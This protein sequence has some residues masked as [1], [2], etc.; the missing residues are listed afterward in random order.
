MMASTSRKR[1]AD[2]PTSTIHGNKI[3]CGSLEPCVEYTK[4]F[5]FP[6]GLQYKVKS[7][8][9]VLSFEYDKYEDGVFVSLFFDQELIIQKEISEKMKRKADHLLTFT[10]QIVKNSPNFNFVEKISPGGVFGDSDDDVEVPP[11]SITNPYAPEEMF[12]KNLQLRMLC[13]AYE[14]AKAVNFHNYQ[15]KHFLSLLINFLS[16]H[17]EK[18]FQLT[19]S[20]STSSSGPF[21]PGNYEVTWRTLKKKLKDRDQEYV[22]STACQQSCRCSSAGFNIKN[23]LYSGRN[24]IS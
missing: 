14:D 15:G 8:E 22:E 3:T 9:K 13:I 5:Q 16:I 10:N 11:V 19:A 24:K 23:L 12:E 6:S 4:Q 2:L 20:M 1:K 17:H 21:Q 18:R 7:S